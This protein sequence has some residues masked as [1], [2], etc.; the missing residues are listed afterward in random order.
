MNNELDKNERRELYKAM[1]SAH[2]GICPACGA[3]ASHAD[4]GYYCS[5]CVFELDDTEVSV[6]LSWHSDFHRDLLSLLGKW[7]NDNK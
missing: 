4:G 7:R 2:D 6:I 3:A 1:R 5:E